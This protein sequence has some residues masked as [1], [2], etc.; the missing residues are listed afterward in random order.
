[1]RLIPIPLVLLF[2]F[3]PGFNSTFA[4]D[5]SNEPKYE[6]TTYYMAFLKKGPNWSPGVTEETK[7]VQAAHLANIEKLVDIGK[8]ILAG[9]F[10]D[11]WEVRGIFVYKVD[12]MEEAIALTEQ[13]PA[14]IAGRL[15]LE[16]HPWYSAKGITIVSNKNE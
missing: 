13:D 7:K 10:L 8:M 12:S 4:Q 16:V 11:E 14:V 3:L 15:T 9:P 1:M 6:M 5:R 2:S